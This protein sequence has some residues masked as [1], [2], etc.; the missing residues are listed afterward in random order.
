MKLRKSY[1]QLWTSAEKIMCTLELQR[2]PPGRK[3]TKVSKRHCELVIKRRINLE[4]KENNNKS[5]SNKD[6]KH[7]KFLPF[8]ILRFIDRDC[9][10]ESDEVPEEMQV[11]G[12]LV[13][14]KG[15]FANQYTQKSH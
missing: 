11:P 7:E 3:K 14:S 8:A 9:T 4:V 15:P 6:E 2:L 5:D 1:L 12:H 13:V 10:V